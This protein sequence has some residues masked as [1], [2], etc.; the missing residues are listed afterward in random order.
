MEEPP[1]GAS[2]CVSANLRWKGPKGFGVALREHPH[3]PNTS[4][5]RLR[6]LWRLSAQGHTRPC[7]QVL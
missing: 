5:T 2:G 1:W 7:E 6:L 4:N 3:L